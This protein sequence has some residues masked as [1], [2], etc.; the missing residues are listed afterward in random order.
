MTIRIGKSDSKIIFGQEDISDFSEKTSID[1]SLRL[2][3]GYL[4]C[5]RNDNILQINPD[6]TILGSLDFQDSCVFESQ[7]SVNSMSVSDITDSSTLFYVSN[8]ITVQNGDFILNGQMTVE[9]LYIDGSLS[10]NNSIETLNDIQVLGNGESIVSNNANISNI[11]AVQS[12]IECNG[13]IIPNNELLDQNIGSETNKFNTAVFSGPVSIEEQ[14]NDNE[15]IQYGQITSSSFFNSASYYSDFD[16]NQSVTVSTTDQLVSTHSFSVSQTGKYFFCLVIDGYCISDAALG[17]MQVYGVFFDSFTS[18]KQLMAGTEITIDYMDTCS[19]RVWDP[20]LGQYVTEYYPCVNY[21]D[22]DG[23]MYD[24]A[25]IFGIA[26][27]TN[28]N[29]NVKIY[30]NN[31]NSNGSGF[32]EKAQLSL[33]K[34]GEL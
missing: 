14:N 4:K 22:I 27:I 17:Y 1:G 9:N 13:D 12:N 16:I 10:T 3:N 21:R 31:N 33:F 23:I 19:R 15:L 2:K 30:A 5:T 20:D 26:D 11:L 34:I 6:G 29:T 24:T 25:A 32:V 8:D 18:V 28:V 7:L